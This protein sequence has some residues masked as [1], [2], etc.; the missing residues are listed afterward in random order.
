MT[1][2]YS[3]LRYPGGKGK[4]STFFSEF[5][6]ANNL[7]GGTYVEPYVGGGS[8]ALFLLMNDIVR[9]IVINDKDRSLF[10]FWHSVKKH[11]DELC[12]LIHDTP[13]T[14]DVW[15]EQRNI[16]RSKDQVDLLTLGFS[17]FFLNR[18]NR[19]GI[20]KGG[21]I[22]GL[23]QTGNYLIDAR[24]KKEH[25]I[26]R[27]NDIADYVDRIELYN[28]DAVELV[29]TLAGQLEENS[30]FYFDPPYYVKGQGLYMNYYNDCD[31]HNIY[32]T[33]VQMRRYKWIVTYD[34]VPFIYNLYSK[35]RM[36]EYSLNYSA[37]TVGKGEEYIVFSN[38]SII[39]VKSA[40]E[41]RTPQI[42]I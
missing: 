3:P 35:F 29:D 2:F 19:S 30:L 4:I 28:L 16:Q 27:I 18:T 12:K 26:S 1:K 32:D 10:A 20:I 42:L 8:I 40:I 15:Y 17:T 34:K 13:I 33:I 9:R 5:F 14:M 6:E 7:V 38:N 37:A 24:Y 21:V 39:P 22:G 25:L 36:Y 31:H 41:L 11:P 23:N